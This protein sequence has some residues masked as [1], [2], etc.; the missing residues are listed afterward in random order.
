MDAALDEQTL[1]FPRRGISSRGSIVCGSSGIIGI[2]GNDGNRDNYDNV[3]IH[4]YHQFV[5]MIPTDDKIISGS[6]SASFIY[7]SNACFFAM[8][9]AL[10]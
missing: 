2:I 10:R 6:Q 7:N 3:T 1:G 9:T 4:K 8:T 5:V